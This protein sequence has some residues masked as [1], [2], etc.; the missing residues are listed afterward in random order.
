MEKE[1]KSILA[2]AEEKLFGKKKE[3]KPREKDSD[4]K[5]ADIK[6]R[7]LTFTPELASLC[8]FESFTLKAEAERSYCNGRPLS[9]KMFDAM[10]GQK[11]SKDF[12]VQDEIA[13]YYGDGSFAEHIFKGVGC[14]AIIL[15]EGVGVD[16]HGRGSLCM[17]QAVGHGTD[18]LMRGDQQGS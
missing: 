11:V 5:I 3:K 14:C 12:H 10:V 18:I 6:S 4:E 15:F 1:S 13:V 7:F 2:K 16:V 9:P 8:G 17:T